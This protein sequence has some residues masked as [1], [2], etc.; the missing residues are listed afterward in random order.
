MLYKAGRFLQVVGMILLPLGIA[1][2]LARPDQFGLGWS[3]TM[4]AIGIGVFG[5]GYLLQQWGNKA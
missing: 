5:L 4:T 3:L 2:N 1:G